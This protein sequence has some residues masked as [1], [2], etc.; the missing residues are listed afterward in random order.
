MRLPIIRFVC[1]CLCFALT[2]SVFADWKAVS[3]I[4]HKRKVQVRL[5]H[6]NPLSGTIEKV[7]G[8]SL[9]LKQPKGIIALSR[10]EIYEIRTS[11]VGRAAMWGAVAGAGLGALAGDGM[12]KAGYDNPDSAKRAG[13]IL[14]GALIFSG[15]GAGIGAAIGAVTG[16][17]KTF[18]RAG[19]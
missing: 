9:T 19:E 1:L 4:D 12:T 16:K 7:D 3:K 17:H 14:L 8:D 11:S 2:S 15:V 5:I 6:G 10:S 18:Y 13:F